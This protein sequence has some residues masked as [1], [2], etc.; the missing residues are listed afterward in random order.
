MKLLTVVVPCY[1][2][3]AYM[4]RAV[5]SLLAGGP[6]L[7][8]LL[9]D[10]GSTD[11]TGAIADEY[12]ERYPGIVRVIHQP[13]GGH[14]AGLNRGIETGKGIYFK[15]LDSDDR[16]DPEGLQALLQLLREHSAPGDQVDLV[17]H[18]Y[19]YDHGE[20]E[21]AVFS[22]SYETVMPTGR[23]FVWDDCRRFPPSKQF[24]IHCMV[25]RLALLREHDYC[26][27]EYVFYEDNL[28]IYQPLPW[29]RRLCYLHRTVYGYN[30]GRADQSIDEKNILRRLD[31]STEMITRMATSWPMAELEKLSVRLRDYMISSVAGQILT[32]SSLH[33]IDGTERGLGM[34]R[35][36]WDRIRA[37]DPALYKRLRSSPAGVVSCLPGSFGR[38]TLVFFYRLARRLVRITK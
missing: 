32:V 10:D 31:Q 30:V 4:R 7:D 14:G 15:V 33:Y 11:D 1:N 23:A 34:N 29:T 17:V 28:Y 22:V 9:V 12:A 20:E 13:N 16:L 8:I 37:Y 26:L 19:V 5:E 35:E 6:E 36:M 3:A 24:M 21:P 25:Y 27:P 2:S 18:D 38:K